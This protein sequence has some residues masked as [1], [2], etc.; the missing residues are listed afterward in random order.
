MT[1]SVVGTA[2]EHRLGAPI[3]CSRG[4]PGPVRPLAVTAVTG[5][6]PQGALR[7]TYAEPIRDR[8][9]SLVSGGALPPCQGE[10]RG[11]ESRRPLQRKSRSVAVRGAEIGLSWRVWSRR[12]PHLHL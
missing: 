9:F 3:P 8:T 10:G 4:A 1:A 5:D 11:F 6:S 2:R 12:A 7:E